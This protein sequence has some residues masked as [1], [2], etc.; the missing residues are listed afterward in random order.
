MDEMVIIGMDPHKA[1]NTIAVLDSTENL[2]TRRRFENSDDG[3]VEMLAAV[4][5]YPNRVWA[6]EGANGMGRSIAQRLVGFDERVYD[7]P[8][9][10]ATRVRVYS[11]G[12]GTKTDN[13]DALA[14]ARAALHS[15]HLRI[16]KPDDETVAVKLLSDRRKE[17]VGLRTQAVC[18]LH[19]LL[20]ELIP[21]GGP[22]LITADQAFDLVNDLKPDDPAG[23]M[24]VE[25]TLEH[26]EDSMRIDLKIDAVA[27]RIHAE[28]KASGTTL[29]RVYGIGPINAALIIGY[30]GDVTRFATA[31]HFAAYNGTAPIEFSSSGH[32][33]HRLSRRGNRTLN[34]AI[35]MIAVTLIRHTHS[36]GRAY[37]DR[38]IADGHKPRGA[39]RAL[40][41]QI[42][43]FASTDNSAST[44]PPSRPGRT[45]QERLFNP[46]RPANPWN[47]G[48]SDQVT[49]GPNTNATRAR[50]RLSRANPN[51]P[52]QPP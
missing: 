26:V 46:A 13:T 20:R 36:E 22:A 23:Q 14:I 37:Y 48:T 24:R 28:I 18:R 47:V 52:R 15:R 7:V 32:T 41:R 1:S 42:S 16:V 5:E 17:L 50:T 25:I 21:G 10:L 40:K 38:K 49:P 35:H 29:T 4:G 43:D 45:T 31:G 3:F 2:L 19:R 9:K 34:H 30:T 11:T 6:V 39:R 44:P 8:A 27:K 51:A 12:H 33:V